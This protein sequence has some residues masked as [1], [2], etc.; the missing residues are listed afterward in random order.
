MNFERISRRK[1]AIW[2]FGAEGQA[3]L[4]ALRR[5]FPE[6][7]LGLIV[8]E[9]EAA[10]WDFSTDPLLTVHTDEPSSGLLAQ[11]QVVIKS[12]GI[13]AYH[14]AIE[15]AN[16]RGSRIVSGTHLWF[17]VHADDRIIAITGTKGKSTV[18]ALVAHLLRA[19]GL[20]IGL[21]GNIGLP[22]L[23]LLEPEPPPDCWV[24]ELSSF[25]TSDLGDAVPTVAVILNLSPEHLDWHGTVEQ[26]YQ[27][28]L[29][30]LCDGEVEVAVLNGADAELMAR[31]QGLPRRVLFNHGAGWHVEDGWIMDG[32]IR[33]LAVA[34][35]PLLGAHNLANVC[36]ALAT[37]EAA[38]YDARALAAAVASFRPLPHRLQVLGERD[39]IRYVNDSIA[40][41]PAATVEAL[42]ALAPAPTAVLIGGFD[43]GI[44]W[45]PFAGP[46]AAMAPHA[47]IGMG[48]HG[49]KLVGL[50]QSHG[51]EASRLHSR[52]DLVAAITHASVLLGGAGTVLL[53]PGAP[54]FDAF[55]DY[56]ER[57]ERFAE[58]AG[59]D[60][61]ELGQIEG[62]GIR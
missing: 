19:G 8:T 25:Q 16:F 44:D 28:K 36:A 31:T 47:V 39:G 55:R 18:S 6:K 10:R 11:Y 58:R 29:A 53:S 2:G 62:L 46:I 45:T 60:P 12:P 32:S 17:D 33:V 9:S 14:P 57:G 59:F 15:W 1:T 30:I 37:V 52:P 21:G 50:L 27:D 26:Y 3:A 13:S 5:L 20:R 22:L 42:R 51:L 54:S 24:V 40:T 35:V 7:P 43:R 41:T 38:G 49:E 56:R 34:D 61:T 48:E 23:E 4:A